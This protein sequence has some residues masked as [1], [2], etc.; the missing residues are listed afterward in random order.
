MQHTTKFEKMNSIQRGLHNLTCIIGD[1]AVLGT[2]EN[3]IS[4]AI[5]EISSLINRLKESELQ[6]GLL[7]IELENKAR[8]LNSCETALR[9][10][11]GL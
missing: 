1:D 5:D 2:Y 4:Q 6:N 10:R 8:L 11:D 7:R 9:E 3:S